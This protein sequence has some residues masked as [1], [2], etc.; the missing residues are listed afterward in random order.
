MQVEDDFLKSKEAEATLLASSNANRVK[1]LDL[2]S[3]DQNVFDSQ[4]FN[5]QQHKDLEKQRFIEALRQSMHMMN[6]KFCIIS[7][8]FK[9]FYAFKH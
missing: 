3:R 2:I 1:V 6:E 7:R 4:V 5:L 9:T 8:V